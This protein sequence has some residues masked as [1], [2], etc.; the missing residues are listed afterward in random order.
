MLLPRCL[1]LVVAVVVVCLSAANLR[2]DQYTITNLGSLDGTSPS[3]A[4]GVNNHGQATGW[5]GV[6]GPAATHA[7]C[8]SGS[9]MSDIDTAGSTYSEGRAINNDGH[10]TG[11]TN[12]SGQNHVFSWDGSSMTDIGTLG[13]APAFGCG[14]NL[15]NQIV[16]WSWTGGMYNE[17]H[18]FV[19]DAGVW[20]D[21]TPGTSHDSQA[22]AINDD[23]QIAGQNRVTLPGGNPIHAFRW[24]VSGGGTDLGVLGGE[25]SNSM[26]RGINANGYV[27]GESQ[28]SGPSGQPAEYHAFLWN[29]TSMLDLGTLSTGAGADSC[30]NAIN[31]SGQ[32]VGVASTSLGS[33]A[34]LYSAGTMTD[35]N[36]L[37]DP[38]SGWVLG[39]AT[40]INDAGQIVGQGYYTEGFQT[41]THAFLLTPTP[42]PST[43]ALLGLGAISLLG[44]LSLRQK[45]IASPITVQL[46]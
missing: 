34:F 11:F 22:L 25:L 20:R 41:H 13:S 7:F 39:I 4:L 33:H 45:H 42:E 14:I 32:I 19:Y 40:G 26:G 18:A 24:N 9:T 46:T 35:L 16:G 30:A 2:G 15:S 1:A 21:L 43:L 8:F 31:S 38:A 6:N 27:V 44:C 12:V 37:I 3:I 36:D 10:V 29:T 5:S 28:I 17:P 23:G